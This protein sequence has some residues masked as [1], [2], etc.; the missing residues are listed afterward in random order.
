MID[1][2]EYRHKIDLSGFIVKV[3]GALYNKF[4][5]YAESVYPAE[6]DVCYLVGGKLIVS[7]V[8]APVVGWKYLD[9]GAKVK[10]L[11]MEDT[12]SP[13]SRMSSVTVLAETRIKPKQADFYDELADL[14]AKHSASI[15]ST[16]NINIQIKGRTMPWRGIAGRWIGNTLVTGKSLSAKSI[17][18]FRLRSKVV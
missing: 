3:D 18:K 7:D 9:T 17:R 5:A 12:L 10:G 14:L 2:N 11:S 13:V 8:G 4:L 6:F 15:T 16:S 1:L